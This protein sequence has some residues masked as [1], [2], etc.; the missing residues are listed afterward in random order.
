MSQ[1]RRRR[2][3][4]V[5]H[6]LDQ[7]LD[8]SIVGGYSG[9]SAMMVDLGTSGTVTSRTG[10]TALITFGMAFLTKLAALRGTER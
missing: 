9:L 6:L 1:P 10:L 5:A 3:R 4:L 2:K 8:S 7:L